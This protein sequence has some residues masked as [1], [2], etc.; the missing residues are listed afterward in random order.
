MSIISNKIIKYLESRALTWT[1]TWRRL[2]HLSVSLLMTRRSKPCQPARNVGP[3]KLLSS[4]RPAAAF[5][6]KFVV[7]LFQISV[8]R[9]QAWWN[10]R[11]CLPFKKAEMGDTDTETVH[12]QWADIF[13]WKIKYSQ[14][15]SHMIID[16]SLQHYS[17]WQNMRLAGVGKESVRNVITEQ[18]VWQWIIDNTGICLT[19]VCKS[20]VRLI[21]K[22]YPSYA[23]LCYFKLTAN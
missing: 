6:S 3:F 7:R 13:C 4:D 10:E 11:G 18:L 1:H 5:L 16:Y 23:I 9:P 8:L 17:L 22:S 15:I 2:H 14:Q 21:A 19:A 20:I 12:A